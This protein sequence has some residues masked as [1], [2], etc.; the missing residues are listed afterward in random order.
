MVYLLIKSDLCKY[1]DAVLTS[2]SDILRRKI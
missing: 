1:Y 2:V